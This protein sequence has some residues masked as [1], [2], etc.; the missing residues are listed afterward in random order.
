VPNGVGV[1]ATFNV[2]T[3]AAVT[4]TLNTPVTL[5]SLQFGNSGSPRTGYVLSGSGS[6]TLT[7]NNS[8]NG[9]TITVT[10]GTHA[11]DAPVVLAENLTVT[12]GGTNPW[13][14]SFGTASSITDNGAG[15]SLTMSDTGGTLILSG[16]DSYTGGTFVEAGTLE[17]TTAAAL[18]AG[19]SFTVGAGGAFIFD[20]MATAAPLAASAAGSV[21]PVPEP[22]TLV[23]LQAGAML[24]AFAAW[25]QRTI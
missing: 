6:N 24:A 4:V 21:A 23:L 12:T 14:L 8:G 17:I 9:A 1:G 10:D 2:P 11:I 22:G 16:S 20:P 5:G 7:F 15:Y 19:T 18:P 13:T 3:T 25:R